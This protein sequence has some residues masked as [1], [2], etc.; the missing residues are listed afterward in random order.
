M[1]KDAEFIEDKQGNI[2]ISPKVSVKLCD[3]GVAEI[4]ES[5]RNFKVDKQGL[6][7]ENEIYQS[8]KQ[9]DG[10]IY[11]ARF[12]D[13]WML[14]MIL[15]EC[16]TNK[17][18]YESYDIINNKNGYKA[19][20]DE[21]LKS[22]FIKNNILKYFNLNSFDLLTKLLSINDE[23]RISGINILKHTWFKGYWRQ[24]K[25][26]INKKFKHQSETLSRRNSIRYA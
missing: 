10:D 23:Q 3:F 16:M 14:G 24:Y 21:T 9:Y 6:S 18:L 4:F 17:K 12:A 5:N 20:H 19:L 8:P 25:S 1:V 13:N 2:T 7:L 15:F 22:Y 26:R 11:D